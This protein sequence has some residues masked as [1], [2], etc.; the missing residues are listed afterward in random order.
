MTSIAQGWAKKN[1]S[2]IL[3]RIKVCLAVHNI[4]E[5]DYFVSGMLK[6]TLTIVISVTVFGVLFFL[7]VKRSL[8]KRLD[9]Y[10]SKNN[11]K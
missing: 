9:Y 10:L 8:K 2:N 5:L 4:W 3:T 1:G 11:K 6:T 7:Y